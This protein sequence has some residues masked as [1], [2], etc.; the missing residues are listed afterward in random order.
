MR[1][2]QSALCIGTCRPR[3]KVFGVTWM[4]SKLWYYSSGT[5]PAVL[6]LNCFRR[7]AERADV[8]HKGVWRP[9]RAEYSAVDAHVDWDPWGCDVGACGWGVFEGNVWA[10]DGG[11]DGGA[12]GAGAGKGRTAVGGLY[13]GRE[14]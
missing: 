6:A 13:E 7:D 2:A 14:C 3:T 11:A 8:R 5:R 12:S 9:A 10:G 1:V 4:L